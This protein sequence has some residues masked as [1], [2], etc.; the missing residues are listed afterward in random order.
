ML[1]LGVVVLLTS[2]GLA[3]SKPDGD[4]WAP[5]R[6]LLGT[7]MGV[8]LG[9]EDSSRVRQDYEFAFGGTFVRGA[10]YAEFDPA[11]A[12]AKTEVHE[13]VGYLSF[14]PARQQIVFRQF[15]SEGFVNTY[16]LERTTGDSLVFVSESTE[17]SGGSRVRVRYWLAGPDEY[18]QEL[19][20]APPE[21]SYFTY[22][23]M[24]MVR[25]AN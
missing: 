24:K 3:E 16:V 17:G 22:K 21:S 19:D 14:D 9:K 23:Q 10:T 15:H 12:G 7:W 2:A 8:E 1:S 18:V 11:E 6:P 13:D 20:L 5:V 25:S 4:P